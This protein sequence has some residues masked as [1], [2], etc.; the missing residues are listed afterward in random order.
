MTTQPGT[1]IEGNPIIND[2]FAEPTRYWHFSGLAPEVR[3][4]R[5]TAGYLAPSPDGQLQITDEVIPLETVNDLRDVRAVAH[6]R[7]PRHNNVT[8]DLFRHWFDD[9][10]RRQHPAV[11]L[12][13]G[14]GRDPRVPHR[15]ARA[16]KVGVTI[17]A[18]GEAYSRWA[19]KMATGTGKTVVMAVVTAWSGLNKTVAVKMPGSPIRSSSS[20]PTS[21][22]RTAVGIGGPRP[23]ATR[24]RPTWSST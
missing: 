7:L 9:D 5:R 23:Q 18:S 3:E 19:V 4:A 11:L 8:R 22:S 24:S 16:I 2:V 13:A 14:R 21:P 20:P 17:P 1:V 6:R 10:R 12:P 15:S